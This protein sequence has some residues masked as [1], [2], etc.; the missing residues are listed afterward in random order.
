VQRKL[1]PQDGQAGNTLIQY[2]K[3]NAIFSN[4]PIEG[5]TAKGRAFYVNKARRDNYPVILTRL[6]SPLGMPIFSEAY[7]YAVHF[8]H[9]DALVVNMHIGCCRASKILVDRGSSVNILYGH[10]FDRM[11]DT[12]ELARKMILS[13]TQ[14]F[15]YGLGG[16]E[17]HS[18]GTIT[19]S[20]RADPYS[21][22]TEF[23]VFDKGHVK[24]P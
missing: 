10:A 8:P 4:S 17:A 6:L 18:P 23:C 1:S 3:V 7:A 13:Q 9:N 22:V 12:P 19:F 14:S 24:K 16:S 5:T 11:K 21:I 2:K 20:V 15:L